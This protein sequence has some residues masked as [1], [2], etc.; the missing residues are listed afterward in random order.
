MTAELLKL[1][2]RC[3]QAP[4]LQDDGGYK[5]D[6][7]IAKA[8][9]WTYRYREEAHS[10]GWCRPGTDTHF[11]SRPPAFSTSLDA[12]MSLVPEGW[13]SINQ[14]QQKMEDGS[15]RCWASID[16]WPA[17]PKRCATPALALCAA[18]LRARAAQ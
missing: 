5:L 11:D 9:G 12:A 7:D 14:E 15:I 2:E 16:A 1:A 6:G 3:E 4:P 10:W 8:I 18:A 17:S 13:R